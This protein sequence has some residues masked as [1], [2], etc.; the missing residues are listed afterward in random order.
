MY[1]PLIIKIMII[2]IITNIIITIAFVQ[3]Q[4]SRKAIEKQQIR[5]Y[6]KQVLK[7]L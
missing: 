1:T 2:M 5:E 7:C 3:Y 4:I 6:K